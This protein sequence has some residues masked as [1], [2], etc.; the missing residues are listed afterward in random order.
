MALATSTSLLGLATSSLESS[1]TTILMESVLKLSSLTGAYSRYRSYQ[2]FEFQQFYGSVFT[3]SPTLFCSRRFALR[4][5][6]IRNG[7]VCLRGSLLGW[8]VIGSNFRVFS[9]FESF[10]LQPS[11]RSRL[12]VNVDKHFLPITGRKQLR[13][14]FLSGCLQP[15]STDIEFDVDPHVTCIVKKAT[16]LPPHSG[17]PLGVH[18]KKQKQMRQLLAGPPD[19][20]SGNFER[21]VAKELGD[22]SSI[23]I[24][25]HPVLL[26]LLRHRTDNLW[27]FMWTF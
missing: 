12:C 4:C 15:E 24:Y 25:K 21:E 9:S 14:S 1:L 26:L 27:N 23:L 5:Q 18:Q 19:P 11:F 22:G 13:D 16:P 20:P 2:F 3:V 8:W 10:K 17:S 7:G 6:C